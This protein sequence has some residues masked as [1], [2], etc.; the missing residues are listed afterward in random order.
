MEDFPKRGRIRQVGL[1][2]FPPVGKDLC[3]GSQ[4]GAF[5]QETTETTEGFLFS[6]PFPFRSLP[7]EMACVEFDLARRNRSLAGFE[8]CSIPR[9][10]EPRYLGCY[11]N[12]NS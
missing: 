6:C 2:P 5:E 9:E 4:D 8:H 7:L 12:W 11:E 10:Y 3:I 1:P